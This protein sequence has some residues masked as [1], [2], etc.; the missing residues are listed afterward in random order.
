AAARV[1]QP[2]CQCG[3]GDSFTTL[4][5]YPVG[6]RIDAGDLRPRLLHTTL[7]DVLA[8]QVRGVARSRPRSQIVSIALDRI[9]E[10][11]HLPAIERMREFVGEDVCQP[12][13]GV[14][15]DRSSQYVLMEPDLSVVS[16]VLPQAR[17]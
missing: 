2:L 13:Q 4:V 11:G 3:L 6:H 15:I 16:G 10:I 8:R 9:A 12:F 5:A 1:D 17:V 14:L 7:V